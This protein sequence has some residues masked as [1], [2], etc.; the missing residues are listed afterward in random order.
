MKLQTVMH[1]YEMILEWKEAKCLVPHHQSSVGVEVV[2]VVASGAVVLVVVSVAVAPVAGSEVVEGMAEIEVDLEEVLGEVTVV[3][4]VLGEDQVD[5]EG[6]VEGLEVVMVVLGVAAEGAD[7]ATLVHGQVE[8]D[9]SFDF[10]LITFSY[11]LPICN[12]F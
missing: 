4:V 11:L 3:G 5:L 9:F 6:V 10:F 1:L 7:C 12:T 2:P 8:D